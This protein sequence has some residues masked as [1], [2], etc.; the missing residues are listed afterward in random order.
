MNIYKATDIRVIDGDTFECV[1]HLEEF[2]ETKTR[3]IRFL[4]I[5]APEKSGATKAEGLLSKAY[6]QT[7]I[8]ES[9]IVELGITGKDSFG[10]LLSIVYLDSV[11]LCEEM[12]REGYAVP[13]VR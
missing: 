13:Y 3:H 7:R 12:L 10:R 2:E 11:N 1:V 5:N 6:V 8:S 9:K 4:G